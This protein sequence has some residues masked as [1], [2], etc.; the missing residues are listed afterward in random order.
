MELTAPNEWAGI[1]K[2][3]KV[4]YRWM[5]VDERQMPVEMPKRCTDELA[6]DRHELKREPPH[7][8]RQPA[9][10]PSTTRSRCARTPAR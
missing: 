5:L 9:P 4:W 8:R 7:A 6:Q 1:A 3:G 10:R 2:D